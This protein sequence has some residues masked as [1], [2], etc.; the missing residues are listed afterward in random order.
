MSNKAYAE[1]TP[2]QVARKKL[3]RVQWGSNN[4]ERVEVY[5]KQSAAKKFGLCV[6]AY[7]TL[8]A[9]TSACEICGTTDPGPCRS[10]KRT[11]CRDHDHNVAVLHVRGMLCTSCNKGLGAFYDDPAKLAAAIAYLERWRER[12]ASGDLTHP[13]LRGVD[14][15]YQRAGVK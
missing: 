2:E 4:P 15:A 9:R 14:A 6:S 7:E 11:W 12:L 5:K 3:R 8:L 10:G 1:M 13:A